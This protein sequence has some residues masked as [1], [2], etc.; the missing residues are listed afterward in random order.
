MWVLLSWIVADQ[1]LT[2]Q[3][4]KLVLDEKAS[5]S[6]QLANNAEAIRQHLQQLHGISKVVAQDESIQIVLSYQ[7]SKLSSAILPL[8]HNINLRVGNQKLTSINKY[9]AKLVS[10]LGVEVVYVMDANG[11][12]IAASNADKEGSFI[13]RDYSQRDYFKMARSIGTGYQ[14]A[15]GSVSNIPGFYFSSSIVV[16]GQFIGVAAAK[17]NVADL[18]SWTDQS[19][20]FVADKFGIIILAGDK[21][22][23]MRSLPN[24]SISDL[25]DTA[26]LGRYKR[27]DFS[28]LEE[29]P[30][31][32]PD[33][34]DLKYFEH[35]HIP[36]L[37]AKQHIDS[38][39]IDIHVLR[40]IP[41]V[42]AFTQN[43]AWLFLLLTILGLTTIFTTRLRIESEKKR[44]TAEKIR[45]ESMQRLQ[46]L[47]DR[48]P[49]FMFEYLLRPDG[50]SCF[51]Y[52]SQAMLEIYRI[53]PDDV[54]NDSSKVLA[55]LH[56]DDLTVYQESIKSSAENQ[57]LWRCEYRVRFEDGSVRWLLGNASPM[58]K[59]DH[60]VLWHGFVMDITERKKTE[61]ALMDGVRQL[62]LKD[63]ALNAASNA[64]VITDMQGRVEW[65]NTAFSSLSGYTLS[66]I[67]GQV[68][69]ELVKSG[70][71]SKEFYEKFWQSIFKRESWHGE[72]LNRR[73][74]RSLY[75]E[76]MTISPVDTISDHGQHWVVVKQDISQRKA[77]ERDLL[78]SKEN[79]RRL[80]DSMAE[81]VF[82]IDVFG[83]IV[84]VN[85]AFLEMLGYQDIGEVISKSLHHL[86]Q[87]TRA[88]G[89][90]YHENES[91]ILQVIRSHHSYNASNEIFWRKDGTAINVEYW[92]QPNLQDGVVI[93]VTG[94]L[95]D[96]SKRV[97]L[98]RERDKMSNELRLNNRLLQEHNE[99]K[100]EE[101]L[102]ARDFIKQFSAL[103]KIN[104]PLVQFML[105]SADNF[106]GDM[107]AFSRTPDNRLH[108]LLADSAGHGLTAA[109]AVIPITQPFY[110]MTSKGFDIS[111]IAKEMNLRV[112]NYL[113]LPR[114]VACV[115]ISLDTESQTIQVW[116]GGCPPVLLLN[117]NNMKAIHQ[118]ESNNLPLGVLHPD[119]FKSNTEYLKYEDESCQLLTC[120]DG[121][122]DLFSSQNGLSGYDE[123]LSLADQDQ[124][125]NI[126]EKLVAAINTKV[127]VSGYKDDIAIAIVQ[128]Q[129]SNQIRTAGIDIAST[130]ITLQK[131]YEDIDF[132]LKNELV[133][134]YKLTLFAPQ[135][136]ILDV[137]PFLISVTSQIDGGRADSKIFLVLSEL[138]N[139]A[140]DHGVLKLNSILKQHSKDMDA[141]YEER[142]KRINNLEFGK[143]EIQLEKFS[144]Q[145]VN[146]LKVHIKDSGDGFN[147]SSLPDQDELIEKR[148]RYGRGIQLLKA[149][150]N[151]LQYLGNGSEVIAYIELPKN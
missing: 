53:S 82:E 118:F 85:R 29:K 70:L 84:F 75:W 22:L 5:L 14:Y 146:I 11:Y 60:S 83:K 129:K 55:V 18:T 23:E 136:K 43:R 105:K 37:L 115:L 101:E 95:M 9:L 121:A 91:T 16:N 64:V 123:F 90:E 151:A 62:Q 108:V 107:I 79:L 56:P 26:R 38:D 148:I 7:K 109:L 59:S 88:N 21:S 34:N 114:Y 103:D 15:V 144:S 149:T 27:K 127:G 78:E 106:S 122:T 40:R 92:V 133:W 54:R 61:Q 13:G 76:E 47:A 124:S 99:L 135:L 125:K 131:H 66:E 3:I 71:Q 150:C 52:A 28:P 134:E 69:G 86:V 97:L 10:S 46:L 30:W 36:L 81:G 4:K 87:H 42:A 48:V 98:E 116:N 72:L 110:Q 93:G 63:F 137:V 77:M 31:Q 49:G 141:Y 139:N 138:F 68:L 6:K 32:T 132:K 8:K 126:F 120:T 45:T 74:N 58:Q 147:Y 102:A 57:T 96:I 100:K 113:P 1:L 50:T 80:L 12:C 143:I 51:P 25:S 17:L 39:D 142:N 112:R 20:T 33:I 89:N 130:N 117:S 65:A 140:L 128:C 145:S 73:K 111:A 94:T 41:S 19:D 67:Q 24:S 35:E 104:D 119:K 2:L 44:K